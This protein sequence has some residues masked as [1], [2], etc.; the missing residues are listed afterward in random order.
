MVSAPTVSIQVDDAR[1]QV[2]Q[3]VSITLIAD[4]NTGIEWIQWEGTV[5]ADGDNDNKVTGDRDLDAEH[6]HE[7]DNRTQCAQVWQITPQTPGR[8]VLRARGR[9]DKGNRSEWVQI[10]FRVQ[11]SAATPTAGPAPTAT[12]GSVAP[13]SA[14]PTP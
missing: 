10:D 9:D 11:G 12:P 2:G 13:A 14:S 5:E 4:D 7:C 1:V 8:Y 6:R 3:T